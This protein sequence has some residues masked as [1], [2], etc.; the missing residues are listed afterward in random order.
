M[1]RY[2]RCADQQCLHQSLG[3]LDEVI[4][5]F[6]RHSESTV[7]L[8]SVLARAVPSMKKKGAGWIVNIAS[9][10]FNGGWG[11]FVSYVHSKER[12]LA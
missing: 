7:I 5:E 10:T 6:E 11:D 8:V 9:I 3:P 12:L 1:S 4:E 2:D